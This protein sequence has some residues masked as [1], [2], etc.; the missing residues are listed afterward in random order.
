MSTSKT[1]G[2]KSANAPVKPGVKGILAFLTAMPDASISLPSEFTMFPPMDAIPEVYDV[3]GRPPPTLASPA[4]T[5]LATDRE[6]VILAPAIPDPAP[7]AADAIVPEVGVVYVNV[8][9]PVTVATHV[10]PKPASDKRTL[11]Y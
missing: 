7:G 8:F 6:R 4:S 1:S 10:P 9:A 2:P 5:V 3:N 11:T